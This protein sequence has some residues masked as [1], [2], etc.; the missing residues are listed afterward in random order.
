LMQWAKLSPSGQVYISPNLTDSEYIAMDNYRLGCDIN[1]KVLA[2]AFG[3]AAEIE[4]NLI[5]RRPCP[6]EV[7]RLPC[8]SSPLCQIQKRQTG[9]QTGRNQPSSS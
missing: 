1:S 8:W 9:R 4:R 3:L 7:G 5:S 6:H 2:F